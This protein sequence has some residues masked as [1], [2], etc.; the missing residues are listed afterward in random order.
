M[1]AT[2]G[3]DEISLY[4]FHAKQVGKSIVIP[5]GHWYIKDETDEEKV[6]RTQAHEKLGVDADTPASRKPSMTVTSLGTI[7]GRHEYDVFL[8]KRKWLGLMSAKGKTCR[9][10]CPDTTGSEH[11][12]NQI[13]AGYYGWVTGVLSEKPQETQEQDVTSGKCT[14]HQINQTLAHYAYRVQIWWRG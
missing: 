2:I 6:L 9:L 8:N 11:G 3:T 4:H 13:E 14:Y 5:E 1:S 7:K 12:T 10:S